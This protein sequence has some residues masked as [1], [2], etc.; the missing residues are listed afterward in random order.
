MLWDKQKGDF[1]YNTYHFIECEYVGYSVVGGSF[2]LLRVQ[3]RKR[4]NAQE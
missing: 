3:E 2:R 1:I 4:G